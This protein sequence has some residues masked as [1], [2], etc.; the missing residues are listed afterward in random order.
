[1]SEYLKERERQRKREYHREWR[2]KHPES[3]KAAQ[4][5]YWAKKAAEIKEAAGDQDDKNKIC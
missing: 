3:V 2:K 5:R 4:M 1:M